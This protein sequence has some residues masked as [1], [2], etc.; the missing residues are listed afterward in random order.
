MFVLVVGL[1][2]RHIREGLASV[3]AIVKKEKIAGAFGPLVN[4]FELT[5]PSFRVP[6][7]V[8]AKN[9][10]FNYVVDTE[11][12]AAVL[13]EKLQSAGGWLNFVPLDVAKAPRVTYPEDDSQAV[14]LI[15]FVVEVHLASD[16]CC[17]LPDA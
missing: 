15:K 1:C 7:E 13:I 14:P 8:M 11:A 2:P 9:Q 16:V 3:A 10:L 6:V 17:C 12:T 5:D 4:L